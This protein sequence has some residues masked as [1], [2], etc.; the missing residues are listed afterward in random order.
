L[1]GLGDVNEEAELEH[2]DS[3]IDDKDC[4]DV[5]NDVDEDWPLEVAEV[6]TYVFGMPILSGG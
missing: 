4:L 5:L 3:F 2:A 6:F 1:A